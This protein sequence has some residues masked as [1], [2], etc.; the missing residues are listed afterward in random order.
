MPDYFCPRCKYFTKIKTHM[1]SH[2]KR[3]RPC[4][5]LFE[6]KTIP[7]CIQLLK[8][9]KFMSRTPT[10]TKSKTF[11]CTK[12]T[13]SFT[14]KFNLVRH[15][16]KCLHFY[17]PPKEKCALILKKKE[18]S[19]YTQHEVDAIIQNAVDEFNKKK[20]I[21]EAVIGELRNQVGLLMMNQGTNI[22][23]NTNIMLNAFGNE[24]TSYIDQQF[25]SKL[26]QTG[27]MNSI[28]KLLKHLHF[29]PEHSENHNIKITNKASSYAEVYNGIGWEET[30]KRKTIDNMTV[31]AYSLINKHYSGCNKYMNMFREN[32]EKNDVLLNQRVSQDTEDMILHNQSLYKK[33]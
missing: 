22:T 32:F 6:D 26:I 3:K 4:E 27:P 12:C 24:N 11:T 13:K 10:K 33:S 2:F 23:Y 28:S 1:M 16:E 19:T 31:K 5:I 17:V 21:H 18:E 9:K 20:I 8:I 7:E 30:N 29:N 14:R 25:I 15:E